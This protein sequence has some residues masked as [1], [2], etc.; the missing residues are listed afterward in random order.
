MN[1]SRRIILPFRNL[2]NKKKIVSFEA[3]HQGGIILKS[4]TV[5]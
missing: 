3:D 4:I 1:V 2:R 5:M